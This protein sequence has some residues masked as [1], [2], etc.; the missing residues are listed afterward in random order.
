MFYDLGEKTV[1]EK[2]SRGKKA[3]KKFKYKYELIYT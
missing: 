1:H 3:Q 2:N